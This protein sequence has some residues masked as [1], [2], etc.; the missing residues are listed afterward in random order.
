[1]LVKLQRRKPIRKEAGQ[2]IY[3]QLLGYAQTKGY[4]TGW[5]FHK[6]REFTGVEVDSCQFV[7]C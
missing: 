4:Q 1:M 3:S 2:H 5:A 6:H 7:R